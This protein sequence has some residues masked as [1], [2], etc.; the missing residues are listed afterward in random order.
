MTD[1]APVLPNLVIVGVGKART[2]SLFEY[3]GQH[4]DICP[5]AVKETDH[6]SP[7]RFAGGV[8]PPIESYLRHFRHCAGS[9]WVLEATPAYC[10]GGQPV[11]DAMREVLGRPRV[12]IILREPAERLVRT[13][14][15]C[16]AR[17]SSRRR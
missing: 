9:R 8:L 13:S 12:V 1:V 4:P 10:Y 3:L 11:I 2:T 6:F 16:R 15:T 14:T 7:L 17:A 5:S